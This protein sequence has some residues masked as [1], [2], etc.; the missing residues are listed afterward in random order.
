MKKA[1]VIFND[2]I[3]RN[4]WDVKMVANVHDEIQF[5]CSEEI[6]DTVGQ[7]ARQSIVEAGLSYNL[8][9]PLD[10]EYKIGKS[11]RDTH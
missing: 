4:K 11:W 1:L 3:T 5:E 9:C 8:R 10:G 6:A 7:A 2:K